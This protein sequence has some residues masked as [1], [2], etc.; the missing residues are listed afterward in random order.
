MRRVAGLE[1]GKGADE[2]EERE[3]IRAPHG[4]DHERD[5][6]S[7][8]GIDAPDQPLTVDLSD[9]R[10]H[11]WRARFF[12]R[13]C[14]RVRDVFEEVR[15]RPK[16]SSGTEDCATT[17]SHAPCRTFVKRRCASTSSYSAAVFTAHAFHEK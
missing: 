14:V 8:P 10:R 2:R 9:G 13:F 5:L 4:A 15:Q 17:R 7:H 6:Q 12:A 11:F 3:E 16:D 1:R